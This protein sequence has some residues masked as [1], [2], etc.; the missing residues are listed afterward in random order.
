MV[1]KKKTQKAAKKSAKKTKYVCY[2][3]G[4]EVFM[5]CCGVGFRELICCGEPMRKNK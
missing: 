5:D 1:A 2:H 3:C 4:K